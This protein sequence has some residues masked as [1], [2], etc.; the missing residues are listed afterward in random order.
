MEGT[1]IFKDD[2]FLHVEVGLKFPVVLK[3]TDV[4]LPE[5][6]FFLLIRCGIML[7]VLIH[8]SVAPLYPSIFMVIII[9]ITI[10][11]DVI[12]L[13]NLLLALYRLKELV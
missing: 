5:Y 8:C 13:L 7:F 6:F 4:I 10:L 2:D 3:R 12:M 11:A 1:I 9:Y